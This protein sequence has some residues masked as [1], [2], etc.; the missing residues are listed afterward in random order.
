MKQLSG[1]T[2]PSFTRLPLTT[3]GKASASVTVPWDLARGRI[4]ILRAAADERRWRL[5][6]SY[7]DWKAGRGSRSRRRG[8]EKGRSCL[9]CRDYRG[10]HRQTQFEH[11]L[12]HVFSWEPKCIVQLARVNLPGTGRRMQ[13]P[14]WHQQSTSSPSGGSQDAKTGRQSRRQ[15]KDWPVAGSERHQKGKRGK[16]TYLAGFSSGVDWTDWTFSF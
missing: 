12:D 9:R 1:I 7:F 16:G 8:K 15:L 3:T 4:L 2:D 10:S 14:S 11:G 5:R 13:M 6:V